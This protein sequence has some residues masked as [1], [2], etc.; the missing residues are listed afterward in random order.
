M[1]LVAQRRLLSLIAKMPSYTG[2]CTCRGIQ[3]NLDLS[4]PDD[5]RTSLCHCTSCKKAF[6]GNY[7]LTAKISK[8]ALNIT[9]GKTKE[10][11]ADNGVH[12]EFCDKC[13]SFICEYGD[14]AKDKFRY[15]VVG[16]LD[17]PEVLPPKGEFFCKHRASWMPEIQNVFHKKEIKE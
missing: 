1:A 8:D 10:F 5:A 4:S 16:S 7:G 6:G 14:A 11:V 13:G 17:D 3:Y 12:R 2:S 9:A 15:I